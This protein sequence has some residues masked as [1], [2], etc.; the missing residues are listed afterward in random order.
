[1]ILVSCSIANNHLIPQIFS[2]VFCLHRKR[3][4]VYH[5]T[6]WVGRDLAGYL[7]PTFLPWA[8]TPATRP[9]CSKPH[10]TWLSTLP[11]RGHPQLL[12]ATCSSASPP[13]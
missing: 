8:G 3:L 6:I 9:G 13:S 1:M 11:E 10:P 7:G 5:R 12:W 4:A 2:K